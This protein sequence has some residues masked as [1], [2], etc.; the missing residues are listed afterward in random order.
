MEALEVILAKLKVS[1]EYVRSTSGPRGPT[2]ESQS[3]ILHHVFCNVCISTNTMQ[4]L[5]MVNRR[6]YR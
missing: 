5:N 3:I 6:R 4:K 2:H 1:G